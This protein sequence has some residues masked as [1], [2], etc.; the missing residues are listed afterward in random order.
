[1]NDIRYN[2]GAR[3]LALALALALAACGGGGGNPG[4]VSGGTGSG[5][6]GTGGTGTGT[7][8][9]AAPSSVQFVEASPVGQSIVIKGQG[10]NLRTEMATVKFKVL[11]I[12]NHPLAG[13]AV[14]FS[15]STTAVTLNMTSGTTDQNGEVITTVNSGSVPTSFRVQATLPGTSISS[16]SDSIVVTTGLPVQRAFSLSTDLANFE[17]LTRDSTPDKPAAHIQVLLAD[18]FGNPVPDG[19]P[20]VFQTNMGSVGTSS[21]GGCNTVNGGCS[22]DFRAQNP[23]SPLPDTPS[24]LCNTGAGPLVSRDSTRPG[25]ATVCASSTDG[26]NSVF[27]KIELF[28]SGSVAKNVVLDDSGSKVLLAPGTV[29]LGTV[30]ADGTR[31]F[32]LQ[33]NDENFNPMPTGTT[34]AVTN[35]VNATAAEPVP[36]SVPN[37]FPHAD[38]DTDPQ[39]YFHT[40]S[41]SSTLPKPCTAGSTASFNVTATTPGGLVTVIPFKLAFS[42]P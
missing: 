1:M 23:R 35:V 27:G 42:C 29:D 9:P 31:Q 3:L 26:T 5:G 21:K 15:A 25:V 10:G 17:G 22:V 33:F 12:L 7:T 39:G 28:F 41:I 13:Q 4:A 6:T 16:F 30:K 2:P 18:A 24:T 20:V 37:I 40:F 32:K 19:T 34:I 36:A 8:A 14:N 11:D 38:S